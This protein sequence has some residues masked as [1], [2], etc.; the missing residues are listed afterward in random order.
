M[1]TLLEEEARISKKVKALEDRLIKQEEAIRIMQ[2]KHTVDHEIL[3]N[4]EKR[5]TDLE[6]EVYTW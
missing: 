5:L 2:N 6:K 1:E 3:S 4:H